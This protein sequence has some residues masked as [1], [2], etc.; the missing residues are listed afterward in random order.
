MRIIPG[1]APISQS[2]ITQ[3]EL[4]AAR[5]H[6]DTLNRELDEARELLLLCS[7]RW[8][9]AQGTPEGRFNRGAISRNDDAY[10]TLRRELLKAEKT[11]HRYLFHRI[12]HQ[13]ALI[14]RLADT[15][16]APQR[17][18]WAR[19]HHPRLVETIALAALAME[20]NEQGSKAWIK[21]RARWNSTQLKLLQRWEEYKNPN[22]DPETGSF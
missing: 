1:N 22:A 13:L 15:Q 4:V 9:A 21:A 7:M 11:Y 5:A 8:Q 19:E 17:E 14:R 20:A 12:P 16:V 18:A 10:L 3:Q 2:E 6:L